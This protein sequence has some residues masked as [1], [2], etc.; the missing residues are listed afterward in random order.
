[1]TPVPFTTRGAPANI[2]PRLARETFSI[3]REL[4]FLTEKELEMQIGH[5]REWWPVALIKELIDNALDACE[6]A[7]TTPEI[8]VGMTDAG[9]SVAD[10]GPGIPAEVIGRSLDFMQRVSD[11]TL[12]VSPTRGQLGNALKTVW[13][14]PY[15]AHGQ[16]R[17]E[18]ETG[19]RRHV[20]E[21][22]LDEI[23]QRPRVS[24]TVDEAA[25]VR[26]G[27]R[28]RVA[29]PDS[30]CSD[31]NEEKH[32]SYNSPPAVHEL[33]EGYAA[34]N[35]HATLRLAGV[36][37]EATQ[38]GFRKWRASDPTSAHWYTPETLGSLIAGYLVR[39]REGSRARTVR[40]FVSEFRG[41]SSTAK[42]KQ[43][44]E[45]LSR[46]HLRDLVENEALDVGIIAELL[47]RMQALSRPVKPQALGVIG[48]EH[49]G[50]WMVAHANV[51]ADSVKYARRYGIDGGLPFVVELAFGVRQADD[52]GRR[53]IYGMNWAPALGTPVPQLST[54]MQQMRM[55][56]HDPITVVLHLA[57][58]RFNF[59]DH[60]KTRV[61]L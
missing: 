30:G 49:L 37:Y 46:V 57:K 28:V 14:A 23:A 17:V 45:G 26:N 3:S 9:F 53:T 42:Q 41:L 12:Y 7:D 27:T 2:S 38:P 18:V 58:P 60:G 8:E 56:P 15:A 11:K 52:E 21:V 4:E 32:D 33:V 35:P 20:I 13:A 36:T 29:W 34:L 43:V 50:A 24:H 1:M 25:P 6:S 48:E 10:N 55:D 59:I 40:E 19:D 16:G 22:A 5:G 61:Q 47:H 51:A 31:E 39:E 44:T 54:L